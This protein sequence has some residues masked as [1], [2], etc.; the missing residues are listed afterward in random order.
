MQ[1][2]NQAA[3]NE[4]E[5]PPT[6]LG[7][8]GELDLDTPLLFLSPYDPWSFRD[9]M[10]S[11]ICFGQTGS[12]KTTGSGKAI[13]TAYLNSGFGGLV[14]CAKPEERQ[15]WEQYMAEC[16][17]SDQLIVMSPE[18]PWKF[19]FLD[20]ELHREG[21]GSGMTENIVSL[22]SMT[23][24]ITEG[25]VDM[26][27]DG[28]FWQR[29]MRELLRN[30]VDI[31]ALSGNQL[32][33]KNINRLIADAPKSPE[34]KESESWQH[35]SFLL[36]CIRRSEQHLQTE[37]QRHDFETCVAFWLDRY[38]SLA[39]RTRSG[40]VATF[41][42]VADLLLHG[43]AW[44]LLCTETT[45]VPEVT[46]KDGAVI[47]LDLPLQ[48]FQEVGRIVQQIFK[49]MFQRAVLRRDASVHPRPVFLWADEAQNFISSYDFQ[50]QSVARSARASTVYLTQNIS[51]FYAVL[52]KGGRDETNSFLGNLATKVFHAQSDHATN[53]YAADL[54][55][56]EITTNFG[57]SSS[58]NQQGMNQSSSGSDTV[59]YKVMPS[60]FATLRTG[61]PQHD[62][63]VDAIVYQG[64]RVFRASGDT[65]LR[66]TFR[67]Q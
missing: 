34:E 7:N 16:G 52:G 64:G 36:D 4:E 62:L 8:N 40:I 18:H 67:Q 66:T 14:M 55:S 42:S 45:L 33:L 30:S 21:R 25:N 39:P 61:G 38:P 60:H 56:Q 58:T 1:A 17:R 19:N 54:I 6:P 22:L 2:K 50:Y 13:A 53:Q 43:I 11:V 44:E 31:I 12:G 49:L 24:E 10:Q 27:G 59:R 65:Y 28:A 47:V 15:L 51:N 26:S 37:R 57:F 48:E 23:T 32:T 20:Y 41:T 29:S 5:F 63:C 46:Y 3:G 9:A 35:H